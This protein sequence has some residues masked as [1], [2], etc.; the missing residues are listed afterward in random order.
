MCEDGWQERNQIHA[1]LILVEHIS[2]KYQETT[3]LKQNRQ[4][5]KAQA[6]IDDKEAPLI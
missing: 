4:N 6:S 1:G 3:V 2:M 5:K